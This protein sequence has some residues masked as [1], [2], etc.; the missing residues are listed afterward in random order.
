MVFIRCS[1]CDELEM[2]SLQSDDEV[3]ETIF[4]FEILEPTPRKKKK[5]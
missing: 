2:R 3:V 4:E 1:C 5:E